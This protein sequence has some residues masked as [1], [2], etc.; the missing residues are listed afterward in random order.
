MIYVK[1]GT[2]TVLWEWSTWKRVLTPSCENDLLN[3]AARRSAKV[4]SVGVVRPEAGV[5]HPLRTAGGLPRSDI[6]DDTID[7][8]SVCC[9]YGKFYLITKPDKN[10]LWLKHIP[11]MIWS[12]GISNKI[13]FNTAKMG[14][15]TLF[16]ME[17]ILTWHASGFYGKWSLYQYE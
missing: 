11:D 1:T 2:Y 10:K 8:S 9:K 12:V 7:S 3:I 13:E 6:L 17:W 4:E 5:L 15:F 14:Q 16:R